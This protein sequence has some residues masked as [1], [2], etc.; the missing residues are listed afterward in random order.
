MMKPKT[1]NLLLFET[2]YTFF[3]HALKSKIFNQNPVEC[4]KYTF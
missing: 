3:E 4:N 1:E 2:F